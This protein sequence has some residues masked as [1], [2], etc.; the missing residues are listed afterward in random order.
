MISIREY[1]ESDVDL[2]GILIADTYAQYNL[3]YLPPAERAAF[4]GPFQHARSTD[5]A[6]RAAIAGVLRAALVLV[7]ETDGQ[8]VGVLRG[9][10]DKLQSLFVRGDLHRQGIGRG[11]VERFEQFCRAQGSTCI[12]VMSTLFAVPFYQAVG[13][14]KTTGVRRMKSFEGEGLEYQPMRKVLEPI[15]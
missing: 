9:R 15:P 1:S 7:A 3:A 11:L 2:I 13:F 10:P 6:H 4:L 14:K 8:I 12:R 5:P